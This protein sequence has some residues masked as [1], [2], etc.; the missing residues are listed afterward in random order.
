MD[1]MQRLSKL[2]PQQRRLVELKLKQQLG[3]IDVL[4]IP[5][6]KEDRDNQPSFP[7]SFGQERLWF[8]DQLEP[9]NPAYNMVR[10]TKLEG[11]LDKNALERS[12][13]QMIRRHEILRTVFAEENGTPS[14]LILPEREVPLTVI[15]LVDFSKEEQESRLREVIERESGYSF[16][17]SKGPLMRMHLLELTPHDRFLVLVL[18]HIVTDGTSVQVFIRELVRFYEA[19]SGGKERPAGLQPLPIQYVDYACWQREWL[20]AGDT[21]IGLIRK[22][23]A[24]WIEQFSGDIPVL[25]LPADFPRPLIQDFEGNI[26]Y[27]DISAAETNALK[28]IVSREKT[29]LYI[30]LLTLYN[31]FLSKLSGMEDIVVGTPV[32]GRRHP[33]LQGMIGMFVN[34]LALRNFPGGDRGLREFLVEMKNRTLQAFEYQ[35]CRYE[36]I[37]EMVEVKRDPGRN[38]L[39]DVMFLLKNLDYA[40]VNLPGLTLKQYDYERKTAMFDLTLS[41]SEERE[42]LRFSFDYC[43]KLFRQETVERFR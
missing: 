31:I 36:D 6:T 39:F 32:A 24:Y 3:G 4:H 11:H 2:S 34:T 26:I 7:L 1:L 9:G 42:N 19:F 25:A 5:I 14:Q 20:R 17:L 21:G 38:P 12:I 15:N 13:R 28:R 30:L 16:D 35:E 43:T 8:I 41:A 18:H 37:I 33:A 22:Q 29:T 27:F 40:E 23:E 10:V